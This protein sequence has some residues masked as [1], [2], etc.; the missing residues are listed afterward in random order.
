MRRVTSLVAVMAAATMALAACGGDSGSSTSTASSGGSSSAAGGGEKIK[1]GLA[2]DIGGRGDKSFNDSAAA[3]LDKAKADLGVE[4]KEL[5]ATQGETDADKE[6][7]LKLLAQGGYNPVIAVGFLY[8]GAMKKVAAAFPKTQFAIIDSVVDGATNVTGLTF[9]ENE[10]S[11]LVGV[12]AALKSKSGN[13]GFIGGCDISLLQKFEVGFIAGAKSVK[14]DIKIQSKYLSLPPDCKGFNDPAAGAETANGMYDAG[15]DVI[16][17]AAGG[18]GTG[19]FQS[20]KAKSKLAIGVDSDQYESAAADLKP[21]IMTSMLKRVDVAVF[22]FIKS[23][24]AGTPLTGV[25]TFDL[26]KDGVGY[27]T[28]GG[29]VDDIKDKL[30]AAKTQITSG[31]VKVPDKK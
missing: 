17:A 18:S 6:A 2:Y 20:A 12:A 1:V 3:G 19:V 25:Q 16:F 11:Y 7:R 23:A 10:G 24:Q 30:E 5:S 13:V 21:V 22:D 15:A 31:S 28:S 29:Q 4:F 14:A 8:G 9:A 27:S 26:K